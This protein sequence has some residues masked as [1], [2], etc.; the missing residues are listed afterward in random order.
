MDAAPPIV[1]ETVT[2]PFT[3]QT[4]ERIAKR[5]GLHI[6]QAGLLVKLVSY[7]LIGYVGPEEFLRELRAGG[8]D[9]A[10]A[11]QITHD[12]NKEIFVP[13][14]ARMEGKAAGEQT[15]RGPAANHTASVPT[16][17][18]TAES[19]PPRPVPATEELLLEDHEEPSPSMAEKLPMPAPASVAPAPV[20][21]PIPAPAA[22]IDK[23]AVPP[24]LPGVLPGATIQPGERFVPPEQPRPAPVLPLSPAAPP[25]PPRAAD[26][27]YAVDPYREP[28]DES[29][30]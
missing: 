10:E 23:T 1:Q 25:V 19:V 5:H 24:N 12:V 30:R 21:A 16:P 4:I 14:R 6:D 7:T 18:Q 27:P 15:E 13:L 29:E 17:T 28:I 9:D 26:K 8:I 22:A 11:R 20:P 3:E 2:S